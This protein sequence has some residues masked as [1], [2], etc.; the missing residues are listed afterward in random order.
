[1]S[2]IKPVYNYTIG[3]DANYLE[4]PTPVGFRSVDMIKIDSINF[5]SL[6]NA[7]VDLNEKIDVILKNLSN[8]ITLRVWISVN[9][10]YSDVLSEYG[11]APLDEDEIRML[12]LEDSKFKADEILTVY[13]LDID[14]VECDENGHPVEVLDL[15]EAVMI[16]DLHITAGTPAYTV[17]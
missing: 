5:A 11:I 14:G 6:S 13:I 10:D 3:V 4:T 2:S 15:Y 12:G 9:P 16:C 8:I 17:H 7:I 1:M